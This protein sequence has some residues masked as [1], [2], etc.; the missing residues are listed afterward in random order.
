VHGDERMEKKRV[1]DKRWDGMDR[2]N[3]EGGKSTAEGKVGR[4]CA[5]LNIPF[6]KT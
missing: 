1:G 4:D 5:V 6:K 3:G 2:E